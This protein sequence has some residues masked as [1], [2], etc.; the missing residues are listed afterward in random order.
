[1]PSVQGESLEKKLSKPLLIQQNSKDT[2]SIVVTATTSMHLHSTT[3]DE[4][5]ISK[6]HKLACSLQ[7][8][9]NSKPLTSFPKKRDTISVEAYDLS[10]QTILCLPFQ[11]HLLGLWL[12]AHFKHFEHEFTVLYNSFL[13]R[14]SWRYPWGKAMHFVER[15]M[16]R[17][18]MHI[19]G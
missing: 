19:H 12:P 18:S 16:Q 10:V 2:F 5:H 11:N 7:D 9:Y 17:H 13:C 14:K 8:I 4:D 15:D 3:Q 6:S 1:M